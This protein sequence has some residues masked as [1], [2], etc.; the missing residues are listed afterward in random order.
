MLLSAALEHSLRMALVAAA[1]LGLSGGC[2]CTAFADLWNAVSPGMMS[3]WV[4]P[5]SSTLVA[6]PPAE[7]SLDVIPGP[8]IVDA[9]KLVHVSIDDHDCCTLDTEVL[10]A[11]CTQALGR[12]MHWQLVRDEILHNDMLR[13][14]ILCATP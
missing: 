5:C 12:Q 3:S 9:L 11:S 13:D 7:S 14:S 8:I 6:S 2:L 4:A 10:L 1:L